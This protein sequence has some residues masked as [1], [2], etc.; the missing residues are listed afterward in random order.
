MTFTV[1]PCTGM[2]ALKAMLLG[3]RCTIKHTYSHIFIQIQ[4]GYSF[5]G[6]LFKCIASQYKGLR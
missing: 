4:E 1:I 5:S 2:H 3:N 6:T